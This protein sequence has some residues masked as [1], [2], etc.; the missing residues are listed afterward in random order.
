VCAPNNKHHINAAR[1]LREALVPSSANVQTV[2]DVLAI[3]NMLDDEGKHILEICCLQDKK[4]PQREGLT[5]GT[6]ACLLPHA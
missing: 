3:M 1:A 2:A 6:S 5:A 4:D